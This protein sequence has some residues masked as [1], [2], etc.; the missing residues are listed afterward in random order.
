MIWS[1]VDDGCNIVTFGI[2]AKYTTI[3]ALCYNNGHLRE[4]A[5]ISHREIDSVFFSMKMS[6]SV[7]VGLDKFCSF[8]TYLPCTESSKLS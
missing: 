2:V 8:M 7:P 5:I 4:A 1:A 3:S 6:N